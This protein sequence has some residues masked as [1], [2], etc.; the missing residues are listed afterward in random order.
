MNLLHNVAACNSENTPNPT[1][2]N[3]DEPNQVLTSIE[4]PL[5]DILGRKVK[6]PIVIGNVLVFGNKSTDIEDLALNI[7]KGFIEAGHTVKLVK[8]TEFL[9]IRINNKIN[10]S[11]LYVIT[12]DDA[13]FS[14]GLLKQVITLTTTQII[15]KVPS[16]N[17]QHDA[18][19]RTNDKTEIPELLQTFNIKSS[20][21]VGLIASLY[22]KE[23]CIFNGRSL[24]KR[25]MD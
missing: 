15:F 5:F 3:S 17:W 10:E 22:D 13:G 16:I 7:Y 21:H 12:C 2:F 11:V 1:I 14:L 23:F 4:L 18:F 9:T 8:A 6:T 19:L 24:L 25:M 20:I